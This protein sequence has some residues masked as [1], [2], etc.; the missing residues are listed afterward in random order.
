[1]LFRFIYLN[2]N[3]KVIINEKLLEQNNHNQALK[4]SIPPIPITIAKAE[5]KTD[6]LP[7]TYL[8][9]KKSIRLDQILN[10]C[11]KLPLEEKY[12]AL[13]KKKLKIIENFQSNKNLK[14]QINTIM[15]TGKIAAN[16]R[17]ALFDYVD[18]N[19]ND[20]IVYKLALS[21]C[22]KYNELSQCNNTL[23]EKAHLVDKGNAA[24]LLDIANMYIKKGDEQKGQ[25]MI[26]MAGKSD[27]YNNYHFDSTQY[28]QRVIINSSSLDF[29]QS[30]ILSFGISAALPYNIF[31]IHEFCRNKS[32]NN[33]ILSDACGKVGK[34]MES[35]SDNLM[36]QA[37]GLA[38][39]ETYFEQINNQKAI[40]DLKNR[41]K[42]FNDRFQNTQL[43]KGHDL[44]PHDE[45]LARLWLNSGIN[46]NE[47]GAFAAVVAEVNVLLENP[48][49]NPCRN[50]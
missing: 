10:D 32:K 41:K 22:N 40:D 38:L 23:F 14:N 27:F 3:A 11:A 47:K 26:E 20:K 24:L 33:L 50:P 31:E 49:Y 12:L 1:V 9:S 48:D 18:K 15:L 2:Y 36:S 35:H 29:I 5:S 42:A 37:F 16:D 30:M 44:I 13:E 43:L 19:P 25:L 6:P 17:P 34:L 8:T 4:P 7:A 28:I 39:Q 46:L 45:N 21:E